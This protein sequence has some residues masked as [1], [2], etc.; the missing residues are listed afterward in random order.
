M[1]ALDYVEISAA[2]IALMIYGSYLVLL[3]ESMQDLAGIIMLMTGVI[4]LI[5]SFIIHFFT[6]KYS[7][8]KTWYSN[9]LKGILGVLIVFIGLIIYARISG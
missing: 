1:K 6:K 3:G 4:G 2:S 5:I 8:A 7:W 9:I